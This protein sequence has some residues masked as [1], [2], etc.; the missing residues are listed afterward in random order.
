MSL[1]STTRRGIGRRGLLGAAGGLVLSASATRAQAQTAGVALVIGNSKYHWEAPLPNVRRDAPDITKR[2][3]AFGLKTEFLQDVGR[4]AMRQAI[5]RFTAASRGAN[6]AA[7]YFAGHGVALG[8]DTYLV[9]VD[10]DLSDPKAVATLIP[11]ASVSTGIEAAV[12]RLMVFDNCRNNPADG[13]RQKEAELAASIGSLL[14]ATPTSPNTLTLYS[15]AP[16][17]IALD[18]RAGENSPFAA[19]LLR[20]FDNPSVDLQ[21]LPAIMRRDLLIATEGRQVLFDLNSYAGPFVLK[22]A[23]GKAATASRSGWANDPSKIIELTNSYAFAQ[24]QTLRL[25]PGLI[26]H[27]PPGNSPHARKVGAF[28]FESSIPGGG[29]T[30]PTALVV[31]SAEETE[32]AEVILAQRLRGRGGWRFVRSKLSG[33][34]LTYETRDRGPRF[35]FKWS[36]ANSGS[37]TIFPPEQSGGRTPPPYNSRFTRLDG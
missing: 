37:V 31:L 7:F 34:T 20:Q 22:G 9:P 29:G 8:K 15:T 12:H 21:G 16:G 24:Q 18:G 11:V 25:P 1:H 28:R 33:D 30:V 2:L 17:R 4:D 19:T 32:A 35:V 5:D 13:W 10:A 6:F 23:P 14:E 36:D 3:Q 26:A 27:R